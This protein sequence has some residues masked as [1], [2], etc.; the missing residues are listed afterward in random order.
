VGNVDVVNAAAVSGWAF[1]KDLGAAP[2][3]VNV[4]VDEFLFA[5]NVDA[6]LSRPD[7]TSKLGSP[8]HGFSVDLSSLATGSHSITVTV[9][10]HLNSDQ[11]EVVIYDGFI[12]NNA[13][14]GAIEVLSGTTISGWAYDPDTT[15]PIPVDVYV[16]GTYMTTT[17]ANLA[18]ANAPVAGHGFSVDLPALTFGSHEVAVYAAESQGNIAVLVGAQTVVNNR[19]IGGI[20]SVTGGS[21]VG[22]AADPDRLGESVQIQVYVNGTLAV[23]GT[24]D[25]PRSDLMDLAPLNSNPSFANYGFT[26][27]LP[28]LDAGTNLIDVYAVDLNNNQL[29]SLGS[30]T[31]TV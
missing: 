3:M 5:A 4:Y 29:S 8:N 21:I 11:Q 24:A 1:D 13:P 30:M 10:D 28:T 17:M 15:D 19:P 7:L 26:L 22:W 25:D 6:N 27:A 9:L 20:E 23:A 18:N 2:A 14:V 16:D 31:V 12:D